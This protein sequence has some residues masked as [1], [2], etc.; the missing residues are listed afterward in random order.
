[1]KQL[2]TFMVAVLIASCAMAQTPNIVGYEYWFDQNDAART[3]VPVAPSS[4][5]SLND[6]PLNTTG[7][8]LG[9]HTACFRLKDAAS[10]SQARW[11]TVVC[12]ALNVTHPGPWEIVAV[13]YWWSNLANPPLGTDLRYRYFDTPQTTLEFSNLLDLC[14][15]PIGIQTLKLQLLDNHGQWSSVVTRSVTVDPTGVLGMAEITATQ[16]TICTGDTVTFTAVPQTGSG[17]ALPTGYEWQVHTGDGW[18]SIPSTGNTIQ[19]TIGSTTDLIQVVATNYCG[20]GAASSFQ[21]TIPSAPVQPAAIS[22]PLQ[23]CG[24]TNAIFTVPQASGVT[25]Q[26]IISGGW[27]ATGGPDSSIS[28]TIGSSDATITVTPTNSC[29]VTGPSR[30]ASIEV[31]DPP[32]AG[33]DGTLFTCSNGL[34]V[35]LFAYLQGTPQTGGIWRRNGNIVSGIYDPATDNSGIFIYI[36]SGPGTCSDDSAIVVVTEFQMPNAGS[37]ADLTLCSNG[38]PVDMTAQ[39]GGTPDEDG[40]WSGPSQ[41]SGVYDPATMTQGIYTYTVLG[42]APCPNANATLVINVVSAPNAGIG[43]SIEVCANGS[44]ISLMNHLQGNPQQ[45]GLWSNDFGITTGIFMPGANP[46]GVY[47]YTVQGSGPC[48]IATA[49]VEVNVMDLVLD[50]ITGPETISMLGTYIFTAMPF[51]I[52]AD[53]IVWTIPDGWGWGDD[54]DHYDD[55][56]QL[57]PPAQPGVYTVC[58]IAYGG[59]GCTG[60]VV[61]FEIMITTDITIGINAQGSNTASVSIYPNP[62]NGQFTITMNGVPTTGRVLV[63]DAL[64]K[65]VHQQ[66]LNTGTSTMQMDVG[67]LASGV[68][69]VRIETE[70]EVV[71]LPVVVRR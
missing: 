27:S 58:A 40:T 33:Q 14:D 57:I 1:M 5:L 15:Y 19:V 62:N 42:T 52:D 23:A 11:S 63:L 64:G 4:V 9:Q 12:R 60:N 68:Y 53:S 6:E 61:C 59:D 71:S 17:F 8:S 21:V 13:R 51:L 41:T 28:T 3:Y 32:D 31:S 18:N 29:G 7:L 20:S 50:S 26:W 67:D 55:E 30:T 38:Q 10:V 54:P 34:A 56:A 36:V 25:Y 39:L 69:Y 2:T 48:A 66:R 65:Q 43:G 47:T 22:G 45:G 49:Q 46:E 44:P 35:Q 37:D 24:G 16:P 70:R